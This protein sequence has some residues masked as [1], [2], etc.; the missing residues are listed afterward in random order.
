M[1][2]PNRLEELQGVW[3][4][5]YPLV[6]RGGPAPMAPVLR[7]VPERR[8]PASRPARPFPAP[9]AA[10]PVASAAGG[11]E[12][13]SAPASRAPLTSAGTEALD[14]LNLEIRSCQRCRLCATRKHAVP[15]TGA[16]QSRVMIL[17]SS[18]G[19][20]EDQIGKPFAGA[21]GQYLDKWLE[22]VG[23]DR[24]ASV[25]LSYV[26][27]CAVPLGTEPDA[28]VLEQ[29]R[30]HVD[31]Q[32]DLIRPVVLLLVGHTAAR[33]LLADAGAGEP[34][35]PLIYRSLPVLV[36]HEPADVLRDPGL[37]RQVWEVLKSMKALYLK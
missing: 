17:G 14:A 34:A 10:V 9:Q 21:A 3:R 13:D 24:Y 36:T 1:A 23:L 37:K 22:A 26:V 35:G 20:D 32:I 19:L 11:P 33:W 16:P 25:Y 8:L 30:T 15:G 29:C 27:H 18:P 5:G 4:W 7:P 28:Q 31:R 2:D 6:V 12:P